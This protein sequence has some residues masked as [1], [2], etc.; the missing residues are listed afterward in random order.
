MTT[1]TPTPKRAIILSASSDIGTALARHWRARGWEVAG[2]FRTPST[3][4]DELHAAGVKLVRCDLADRAAVDD[5][6]RLLCEFGVWDALVLCPGT[7][8]PVGPFTDCGFDGWEDSLRINLLAP[9]RVVQGLLPARNRGAD[10]GVL[11]FAGGGTNSATPNYSA[12]TTAKIALVKA[13]ELLDAEVPDTR[14]VIPGTGWVRTKIHEA[15]L[16]AGDRAGDNY[17]RTREKLAGDECTPLARV[18]EFCDWALTAPRAAVS[19]RNFSV[20]HDRW[21]GPELTEWL[22]REPG[23]YKLRRAGN[24]WRAESD[25]EPRSTPMTRSAILDDL[26]RTLPEVRERHAPSSPLYALL[27]RVARQEVEGLFRA[28]EQTARGFGPFGELTFPYFNMGS[29]DSLSLFDLDELILFSFYHQNRSRYRHVLDIGANVGL[30]SVILDRCG[31]E[32]RCFEPDPTHFTQ[33]QRNLELNGCR[34]VVPTRAAVSSA[35]G[36]CEFVR[37]LGNTTGSHLAGAKAA[38]YGALERF[39]VPVAAIGPLLDWADLVKMDVEG[40]E[41][42]ILLSTERRHWERT[43]G[44]VEIGTPENARAV[45]N[46]FRGLSARL[47]AQKTGWGPVAELAD[48]PTSYRDGS[49]FITCRTGMPW[50]PPGSAE[51]RKAA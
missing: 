11:F 1:P 51:V 27:K 33:L 35:D 37:V 50:E 7:L 28:S 42:E 20:P 47:F 18:L 48:M 34:S 13:C 12:Y 26:L 21:G 9:L 4:V 40:H 38:P 23:A 19:G 39:P 44:V 14:F 46:H 3:A 24:D 43:D 16:R 2:T 6:C 41:A 30:H 22:A 49:L 32:V 29:V 15:T 25:Q 31:F 5:A 45:F 8:E 10:P 17:H 36:T